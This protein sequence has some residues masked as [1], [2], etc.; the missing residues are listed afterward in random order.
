MRVPLLFPLLCKLV[1]FFD[2]DLV[3]SVVH[4]VLVNCARYTRK[5]LHIAARVGDGTLTITVA[6]DGAGYPNEMLASQRA[7]RLHRFQEG[8]THLGLFFAR[9]VAV[10]HR[11]DDRCGFVELHNG[12]ELGGDVFKLCLP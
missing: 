5:A 10:M 2:A 6:D 12:G 3:G 4:N 11:Q 1:W 7:E 8:S 9:E